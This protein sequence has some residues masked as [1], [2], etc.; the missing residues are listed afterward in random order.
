MKF[1]FEITEK[2]SK[3]IINAVNG[4]DRVEFNGSIY[5]DFSKKSSDKLFTYYFIN[6]IIVLF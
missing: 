3:I 2:N 5:R 6:K 1:T 4:L